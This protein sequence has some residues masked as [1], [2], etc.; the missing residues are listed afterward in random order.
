[1][2][3]D[4]LSGHSTPSSGSPPPPQNRS[5]SPG[6]RRPNF[7]APE[8]RR[9][10]FTPRSSSLNPGPRSTQTP[11]SLHSPRLPS[12]SNLKQQVPSP[13]NAVDPLNVLEDIIGRPIQK[14]AVKNELKD[15][16]AELERLT[17]VVEEVDFNGL[18]LHAFIEATD[19]KAVDE[20][21]KGQ[22]ISARTIKECEYVYPLVRSIDAILSHFSQMRRRRTSLKIYINPY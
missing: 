4:R 5:H 14:E 3:L 22:H 19:R 15:S 18:S 11:A 17:Q 20:E 6:P 2:W 21:S 10:S 12:G 1:M 9:P 7:L 16:K 13:A 8:H